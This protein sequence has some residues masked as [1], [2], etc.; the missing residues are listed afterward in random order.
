ML[1]ITRIGSWVALLTGLLV[2]TGSA[3]S[4]STTHVPKASAHNTQSRYSITPIAAP[5][6]T[7]GYIISVDGKPLIRQTSMPALPG[8]RGFSSRIRAQRAARLVV[9]KLRQGQMPPTLTKEELQQAK[10]I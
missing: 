7:W 1:F 2:L 3:Q 6:H 5:G 10:L 4:Q 9:D 8:N